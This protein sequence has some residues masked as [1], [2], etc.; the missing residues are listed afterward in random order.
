MQ[1]RHGEPARFGRDVFHLAGV[2]RSHRNDE[3]P[4]AVAVCHF[5]SSAVIELTG[6]EIA[7]AALEQYALQ[8]NQP[9]VA[10][11]AKDYYWQM[12]FHKFCA[13]AV[14]HFA[15]RSS[16]EARFL[17]ITTPIGRDVHQATALVGRWCS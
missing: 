13:L 11:V 4:C 3:Q 1:Y 5:A 12:L 17:L 15:I 16:F 14:I 6:H 7:N 9:R 2:D 8:C 10:L